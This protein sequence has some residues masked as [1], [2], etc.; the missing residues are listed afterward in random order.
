MPELTA[1]PRDHAELLYRAALDFNS[2]L[3]FDELLPRMFERILELLEAEAGSIWLKREDQI[4]CHIAR[5]P[6]A[7]QLEGLELPLGVGIVGDVTARGEPELVADA[8]QDPRFV[9]QVDEATGFVTRSVLTVP[10]RAQKE[11]LGAFQ[12]LN[13]QSG[14]G[15]FDEHDLALL[16]GLARPAG[17]A[18]RNAQLHAV[19]KRARD[20]KALLGISREI[21]STLDVDR[22]SMTVVN[23]GSQALEY[24]RAA[25]GL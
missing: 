18:L 11:I 4:V 24:D 19:E 25:I 13:K 12:I 8:R 17:L 5:G 15:Q 6:A 7:D 1:P 14:D 9:H 23:L 3:D 22:L 10:L 20:F 21:T 2:T 16:D